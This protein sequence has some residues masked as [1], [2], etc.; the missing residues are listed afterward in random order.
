MA[1]DLLGGLWVKA[2]DK[3]LDLSVRGRFEDLRQHLAH[4]A[5]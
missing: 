5:N 4:S 2:G 1:A 3:V